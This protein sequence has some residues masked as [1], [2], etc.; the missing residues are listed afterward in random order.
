MSS[1]S[2]ISA[3]DRALFLGMGQLRG[4]HGDVLNTRPKFTTIRFDNGR[5]VL[6]LTADIHP[7]PRRP[8]P[9]FD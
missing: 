1:G 3:G 2:G 5:A 6:T 7:I 4:K 8:P 9:D